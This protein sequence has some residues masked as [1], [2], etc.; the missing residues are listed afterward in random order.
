MAHFA[1]I[2][3]PFYSHIRVFEALAAAL[4][5][6]GHSTSFLLNAGG[7]N[8]LSP[9]GPPA[10]AVRD[11]GR[12][13]ATITRR[14]AYPNGPFGILRTVADTAALTDALCR[15]G[16]AILRGL[17]VDAV[18][19]D[20]MEPAAGLLAA[21]LRLPQISLA[22]A[23]PVNAAP[24]VPLPFLDWPYDPSPDGLKRNRGGEKIANWLLKGQ[25]RTIEGWAGRFGLTRRSSLEDCLS[26]LLQVSQCPAPF[27]FPRTT[28]PGFHAVGPI[29]K[30]SGAQAP[31]PCA[32]DPQR[33]FVFASLGT[34]QGHR[35]DIFT[36]V[37]TAC[38]HIGA[39]L[40]VAHCGGLT[41]DKAA[42]IDADFV[43]D[44]A[45]QAAVLARADACVTHGGMNTVLDALQLRVPV[46]VIPIAFDQP[47]I[48][49]RVVH[50]GVGRKRSRRWLTA[51]KV[52][53]DLCALL[54]SP[55]YR[56][57]AAALG[58][59]LIAADGAERAARLIEAALAR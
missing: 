18:I 36:R 22:C 29:R 1:L 33:P 6:R 2:C 31:L 47:G 27:D 5:A 49:A 54:G 38:R 7:E 16:P 26:P 8:L 4:A 32:I 10:H 56:D 13:L 11:V 42:S 15:D 20:Q 25:R 46:L 9:G 17:G 59:S 34:L 51:A 39:Q 55:R 21:H 40:L 35:L 14:A 3:P 45:P 30:S 57:A 50:H 52:E 48:A 37:A 28:E 19:G 24:G 53:A 41:P 23:L 43:T 58:P 44:F 12:D